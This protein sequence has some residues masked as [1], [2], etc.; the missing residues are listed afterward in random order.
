[1][2]TKVWRRTLSNMASAMIPSHGYSVSFVEKPPDDLQTECLICFD[3]LSQPKRVSCCGTKF[4]PACIGFIETKKSRC[5]HCRARVFTSHHDKEHKRNINSYKVHCPNKE[6]GCEWTG[7]LSEC[8]A[9]INGGLA[10]PQSEA[11]AVVVIEQGCLFQELD[12]DRCKAQFER[13]LMLDHITHRCPYRDV[14]CKYRA[15]GCSVSKR[16][17]KEMKEH[18]KKSMEA[19]LSLTARGI[20]TT[21]RELQSELTQHKERQQAQLN[22][23]RLQYEQQLRHQQEQLIELQDKKKHQFRELEQNCHCDQQLKHQQEQLTEFKNKMKRR[24]RAV[25][26]NCCY[27][28]QLRHQQEQLTDLQNKMKRNYHLAV[29]S[30]LLAVLFLTIV[31]LY[32]ATVQI[33]NQN[34]GYPAPL[35]SEVKSYCQTCSGVCGIHNME[36]RMS[37][38]ADTLTTTEEFED[39]DNTSEENNE[40]GSYSESQ[41][42]SPVYKDRKVNVNKNGDKE[43]MEHSDSNGHEETNDIEDEHVA[44]ADISSTTDS[45]GSRMKE[46]CTWTLN[47]DKQDSHDRLELPSGNVSVNKTQTSQKL[48]ERESQTNDKVDD[49]SNN[50]ESDSVDLPVEI[51]GTAWSKVS[52]LSSMNMSH[53]D[54]DNNTSNMCLVDN[55]PADSELMADFGGV[56]ASCHIEE[57]NTL[58]RGSFKSKKSSK[59]SLVCRVKDI[60]VDHGKERCSQVC[61]V[62]DNQSIDSNP[63]SESEVQ[64]SKT[65]GE[66]NSDMKDLHVVNDS[67]K[68]EGLGTTTSTGVHFSNSLVSDLSSMITSHI[69][70]FDNNTSNMCLVDNDPADSKLRA[71][72]GGV[73]ASCH[74]EEPNT[75]ER[76]SF[77]SK[78]S[79]KDSLVCRVKDIFVDHGKERC[80]QVCKVFDNQSIDSKSSSVSEVQDS[81]TKG[82]INLDMKDLHVV[83][84]SKKEEGLGTTASDVKMQRSIKKDIYVSKTSHSNDVYHTAKAA[85]SPTNQ[86]RARNVQAGEAHTKRN[87]KATIHTDHKKYI[88][89]NKAKGY[90][91]L[92]EKLNEFCSVIITIILLCIGNP[93]CI[94]LGLLGE[95]SRQWN[96]NV[97]Y[98]RRRS[99]RVIVRRF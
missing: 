26:Q 88:H 77:K 49:E 46:V 44:S 56:I 36:E 2:N 93:V 62:F 1:M 47:C 55:D 52:D 39:V 41:N 79:S 74:I 65:K 66:I 73:I 85:P 96:N 54:L 38:I 81:K 21:K 33:Q 15:L 89:D 48:F 20:F 82:E 67:K 17:L 6:K 61:K 68:E 35:T 31:L 58:E 4:C 91:T 7:G 71:D 63:S 83:N 24:F 76:G 86:E 94:L 34:V 90:Q 32:T 92:M 43:I 28:Q 84:D 57:P 18:T 5:P 95:P 8:D 72:F 9:H 75:L 53:T 45:G 80:S 19:H 42:K 87:K 29:G 40:D 97:R 27:D 22:Q 11:T 59:D 64:D 30:L 51:A 25:E 50:S 23:L 70:D 69:M 16:P 12:C 37:V 10:P 3:T 99:R 78:K 98:G 13:R 60:F 14:E